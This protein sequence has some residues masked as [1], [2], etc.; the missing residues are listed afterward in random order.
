V[1]NLLAVLAE[2]PVALRAYINLTELL[3]DASLSPIK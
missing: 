3:G 2:A 1:P